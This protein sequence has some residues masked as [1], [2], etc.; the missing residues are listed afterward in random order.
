[1]SLPRLIGLLFVVFTAMAAGHAQGE[2]PDGYTVTV[3]FALG[4]DG[5]VINPKVIASDE[6]FLNP[7]AIAMVKQAAWDMAVL[8][9]KGEPP[10]Q[11]ES[12]LF[13]PVDD[14]EGN[15]PLPDGATKPEPLKRKPP[16]YPH[17]CRIN[18][19]SGGALLALTIGADGKVNDCRVIASSHKAFADEAARALTQ[20]KFRPAMIGDT[21]VEC[22]VNIAV[23]FQLE[24]QQSGW[25]WVIA[26][27]PALRTFL[28]ESER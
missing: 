10:K 4:A 15:A 14:Y 18:G 22:T 26:P 28:V 13:F 1:M 7:Y 2:R 5:N 6:Q 12:P 16:Y 3:R 9:A 11:M 19:I 8:P 21:T 25:R 24:G 23:P 17:E 27:V 20:W